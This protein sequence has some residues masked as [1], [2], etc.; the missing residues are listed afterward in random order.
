IGNQHLRVLLVGG[1]RLRRL[2]N[3]SPNFSVVNNYGPTECAVVATSGCVTLSDA[4]LHIGRPISNAR[5]YLLDG[6]GEPVPL[7]VTGE[8]HIGGAGVARG[9]LNRPDLTA[10]RF[11]PDR[12]AGECGQVG[13]RLYRTGDLARWRSDGNIDFLGRN[14]FQVKIR[15]F[16]IELGEIEARLASHPGISASVVVAAEAGEGDK[17][18][19]AYYTG[20]PGERR[21]DPHGLRSHLAASLPDYMVPSAFVALD[22]LPL[23]ANG[24]LDRK[25]L[26][27]PDGSALAAR[28][29]APPQGETEMVLARIWAELLGIGQ[30]GRHDNF[31][32]LG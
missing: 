1:D 11:V 21:P 28:A 4:V 7:G 17:R 27:A 12:F 26:P 25:A 6:R 23:T 20:R 29:Y 3:C 31:F 30:V 14:D 18:L 16:R 9:Y 19:V 2:P 8:I 24:K 10:E 22:A 32:E 15:G 5:I 13:G